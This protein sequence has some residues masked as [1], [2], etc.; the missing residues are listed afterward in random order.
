LDVQRL[1][2]LAAVANP[3]PTA[4]WLEVVRSAVREGPAVRTL[5]RHL[6]AGDLIEEEQQWGRLT[7]FFV[8]PLD[9]AIAPPQAGLE[10]RFGRGLREAL[11][12]KLALECLVSSAE[13]SDPA[14]VLVALCAEDKRSVFRSA[15]VRG[16]LAEAIMH[17]GG[18]AG[19][20]SACWG[21][22]CMSR[23]DCHRAARSLSNEIEFEALADRKVR[24]ADA[25]VA[26]I[27]SV[28][29]REA[30]WVWQPI[31]DSV[32]H[33]L[34][35]ALRDRTNAVG[36]EQVRVEH[37]GG[38]T[39]ALWVVVEG[40]AVAELHRRGLSV[41]PRERHWT[42]ERTPELR[43]G[44]RLLC[45]RLGEERAA[46]FLAL[47]QQV[48]RR[49]PAMGYAWHLSFDQDSPCGLAAWGAF[50]K[51]PTLC[52]RIRKK[53]SSGV[54]QCILVRALGMRLL[55]EQGCVAVDRLVLSP[56]W[57]S[58]HSA[59]EKNPGALKRLMWLEERLVPE[60][61]GADLVA[62][63]LRL[64]AQGWLTNPRRHNRKKRPAH[65][66]AEHAPLPTEDALVLPRLDST[67]ELLR[68]K[69]L[70]RA[71]DLLNDAPSL[72]ALLDLHND[73]DYVGAEV[74]R[75]LSSQAA[76][77]RAFGAE[78]REEDL[79][80]FVLA[81]GGLAPAVS[82]GLVETVVTS[83]ALAGRKRQRRE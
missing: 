76:L 20:V 6:G 51:L 80:S 21:G 69:T 75:R 40:H 27:G 11:E 50:T 36:S 49:Q 37:A 2:A 78:A 38:R 81:R 73:L 44:L 52:E 54:D 47:A 39:S 13:L 15:R 46:G 3:K 14:A 62:R 24:V 61:E 4:A 72:E 66:L 18:V 55:R 32:E 22:F 30:F 60:S 19:P 67:S 83:G 12:P 7:P 5:F 64:V 1:A 74:R 29:A 65:S 28:R 79:A 43:D 25:A 71:A 68:V 56:S 8:E 16:A 82:V 53:P 33:S 45:Q 9:D 35:N 23:R 57:E 10:E 17:F 42:G 77:L 63:G 41:A 59:G 34:R 26:I 70:A 31:P 58:L 48:G